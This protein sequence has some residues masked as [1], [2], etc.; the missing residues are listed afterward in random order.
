MHIKVFIDVLNLVCGQQGR[1]WDAGLLYGASTPKAIVT[2]TNY[3]SLSSAL[4]SHIYFYSNVLFVFQQHSIADPCMYAVNRVRLWDAGLLY[5]ASTPKAIVTQKLHCSHIFPHIL[6]QQR[7]F[8]LFSTAFNSRSIYEQPGK[9]CY[10]ITILL[11]V[12]A[13]FP[14]TGI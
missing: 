13:Q 6:L 7:F 14:I 3:C 2:Q 10:K 5:G 1:S 11:A 8:V 12:S 9:S 4:Y